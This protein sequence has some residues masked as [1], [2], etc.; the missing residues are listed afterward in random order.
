M[1]TNS[2][3]LGCWLVLTVCGNAYPA[4]F[5][6]T[7]TVMQLRPQTQSVV[8]AH[9]DIPGFMP[10][11]TMPFKAR[12]FQELEGIVVGNRIQ[13]VF[14]VSDEGSVAYDFEIT[15][16]S[17]DLDRDVVET[18]DVK[19][20]REGDSAP[21]V[22][23]INQDG[24]P[25]ALVD[26]DGRWTVMT[27]IFVRCPVPEFCPLMSRKFISIQNGL[28]ADLMNMTRLLSITLDPE[29]D[30]PEQLKGYGSGFSNWDFA[31]GD[32][33]EI[34]RLTDAFR[35]YV[36]DNGVTLDHTLCTV[37]ISPEGVVE[38]VWRGNFWKPDEVISK[39]EAEV[40]AGKES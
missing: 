33:E 2:L 11:M 30:T 5:E 14:E 7:G 9:D 24:E 23:L 10:A 16:M 35:V 39:I 12:D 19:K 15:G 40:G 31:T 36:K 37:L 3:I 29:Y 17:T 1:R 28:S 25:V 38:K 6:V 21:E 34:E 26:V 8:V 20:V 22:Q 32:K 4:L 18:R 13:F 27:F